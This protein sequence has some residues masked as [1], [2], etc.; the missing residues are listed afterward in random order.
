MLAKEY[1]ANSPQLRDLNKLNGELGF[2]KGDN[3]G[4][5]DK[6]SPSQ[7]N[8]LDPEVAKKIIAL[9]DRL[10][11]DAG[12]TDFNQFLDIFG[13]HM[14]EE[15]APYLGAAWTAAYKKADKGVRETM[16]PPREARKVNILERRHG[17]REVGPTGG[18][19]EGVLDRGESRADGLA[20]QGSTTQHHPSV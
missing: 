10:V 3:L 5:G 17:K 14:G 16:A 12:I 9:S 18:G 8:R 11:N 4:S 7:G 19:R 2:G 15:V 6:G 20:L 1:G 13:Q